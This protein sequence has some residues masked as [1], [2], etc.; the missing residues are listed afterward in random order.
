MANTHVFRGSD[1][2]LYLQGEEPLSNNIISSSFGNDS[3]GR[4]HNVTVKVESDVQGYPEMGKRL[5]DELRE[6]RITVMG[7]IERAYINGALLRLL[8][9]DYANGGPD[10]P[11]AQP[12]F[13]IRIVINNP[14]NSSVVER[15][16]MVGVK[17]TSWSF[18]IPEDN[19]IMESLNFKASR[20]VLLG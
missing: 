12:T 20:A 14:A 2:K 7:N 6:G 15:L 18:H 1:A 9:G 3:V 19:F 17:F 5:F 10:T 13:Q 8:L 4:L 11:L 16:R